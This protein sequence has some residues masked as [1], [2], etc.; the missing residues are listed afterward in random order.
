MRGDSGSTPVKGFYSIGVEDIWCCIADQGCLLHLSRRA[1]IKL[2]C[3]NK[4]ILKFRQIYFSIWTNL[5]EPAC[6]YE[7]KAFLWTN[8]FQNS[9][10]YIQQF[11]QICLSRRVPMKSRLFCEQIHYEIQTNTFCNLD[12]SILVDV[13]PSRHG[14]SAR[15]LWKNIFRKSD[16]HIFAIYTNLLEPKFWQIH[17]CWLC[18]F[19]RKNIEVCA[20]ANFLV[21]S[22]SERHF[23]MP[24]ILLFPF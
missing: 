12:K 20:G 9:D 14:F 8:I 15:Y 24:V 17:I 21:Y 2:F 4:Y 22:R 10:K 19:C 5:L 18:H 11:G 16:K 3:V 1:P 6:A 13:H 23:F 7:V